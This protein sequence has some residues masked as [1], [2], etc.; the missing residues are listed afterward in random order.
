MN[1]RDE[2][3][4]PSGWRVA[5]L[6]D[7][8]HVKHGFAFKSTYF[9]TSGPHAL[10]TPGNFYDEGGFKVQGTS[11]NGIMG[12]SQRILFFNLAIW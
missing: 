2:G 11:K 7:H 1:A 10:L 8:I 12:Q 5:L 9:G 6:K 3:N 4:L